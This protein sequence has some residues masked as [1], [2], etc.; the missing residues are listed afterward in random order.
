[1]P[2]AC[3]F[4]LGKTKVAIV[5]LPCLSSARPDAVRS[6]AE[7]LFLRLAFL[8]GDSV[9]LLLLQT[10]DSAAVA[11]R[12]DLRRP[13]GIR[14]GRLDQFG[15]SRGRRPSRRADVALGRRST[16]ETGS[17]SVQGVVERAT[18]F[19]LTAKEGLVDGGKAEDD[20]SWLPNVPTVSAAV[21]GA[22][23]RE[24]PC[25]LAERRSV[26]DG[27]MVASGCAP[28]A[29]RLLDVL[30]AANLVAEHM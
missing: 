4:S 11:T 29:E 21:S 13:G 27:A 26:F 30:N 22:L 24:P 8:D 9:W 15:S 3:D 12:D 5:A 28:A 16:L 14:P 2:I 19:A 7:A 6:S 10:L 25:L 1:M 18:G 20:Y 23:R 17:K